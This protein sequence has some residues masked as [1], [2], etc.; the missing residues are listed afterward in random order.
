M[1][2]MKEVVDLLNISKIGGIIS[3][4]LWI[5]LF[6]LSIY[7][8]KIWIENYDITINWD[9]LTYIFWWLALSGLILIITPMYFG[10]KNRELNKEV[11]IEAETE[12]KKEKIKKEELLEKLK[13]ITDTQF[14]NKDWYINFSTTRI[15]WN[16]K[17]IYRWDNF[18]LRIWLWND[19][20]FG[21]FYIG[22]KNDQ[23]IEIIKKKSF[24]KSDD[25]KFI[26]IW[27]KPSY[28]YEEEYQW[29]KN[30]E[31]QVVD[32]LKELDIKK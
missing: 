6:I 11:E 16:F 8:L 28:L 32:I 7:I 21:R 25:K 15:S 1:S 10:V 20:D 9:N 18:N 31:E 19:D 12:I 27:E 29:L 5:S 17:E 24:I 13:E 2:K 3:W 23:E 14:K 30:L 22:Q 4:I 26:W